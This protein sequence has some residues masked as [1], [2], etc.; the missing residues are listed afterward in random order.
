M[1]PTINRH[2]GW[3]AR[4]EKNERHGILSVCHVF[5]SMVAD[6]CR[7]EKTGT[8]NPFNLSGEILEY[9]LG[10]NACRILIV[11]RMVLYILVRHDGF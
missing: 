7:Q 6:L 9:G 8:C 3:I 10:E 4:T 5:D 2:C 1:P 11:W